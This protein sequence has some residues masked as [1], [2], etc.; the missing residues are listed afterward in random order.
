MNLFFPAKLTKLVYSCRPVWIRVAESL[1]PQNH[2]EHENI[3]KKMMSAVDS[4]DCKMINHLVNKALCRYCHTDNIAMGLE[5]FC[6]K[7]GLELSVSPTDTP[8]VICFI[9]N[10][11]DE[12]LYQIRNQH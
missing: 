3:A 12:I 7:Y 1:L 11:K 5:K 8:D 9:A 2:P 10:H 4:Y 6:K